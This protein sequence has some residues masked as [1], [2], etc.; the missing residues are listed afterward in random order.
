[1]FDTSITS[2]TALSRKY[3]NSHIA[4]TNHR[5]SAAG[6]RLM[7]PLALGDTVSMLKCA[8]ERTF[9]LMALCSRTGYCHVWNVSARKRLLR[10][11][12]YELLQSRSSRLF[13]ANVTSHGIPTVSVLLKYAIPTQ[14]DTSHH[15]GTCPRHERTASYKCVRLRYLHESLASRVVVRSILGIRLFWYDR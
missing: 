9:V 11:E 5:Y 14:I 13:D 3:E 7:A 1:M 6:R 12:T 15:A 4:H 8:P 2:T 10:A